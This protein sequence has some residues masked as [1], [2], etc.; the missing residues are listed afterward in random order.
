LAG[1]EYE[2]PETP[3]KEQWSTQSSTLGSIS[4]RWWSA[5]GDQYLNELIESAVAGSIDLQIAAGRIERAEALI[6][7]AGARRLPIIG[8]SGAAEYGIQS[9]SGG[10]TSSTESYGLGVGLNWEIDVWGK[11]KKGVAAAEAEYKAS[12]ADWRSAYL[13]LVSEAATEY[14]RLRQ[15][16]EQIHLYQRS[17]ENSE[18]TL[19][20]Y[21]IRAEED[22]VGR[23]VVLRQQAEVRR[24]QRELQDLERQRVI[25]ENGLA[26][27][28][29]KPAG[30]LSIPS[31]RMR[32]K[33]QAVEVPA[34][35]PADL[36]T[37]R[38]DILAAEYRV[39]A[40]YNLVGKARLDRLPS[41]ALTTSGG[42]A[43][44]SIGDLLTQWF[45]GAGPVISVPLFDPGRRAEVEVRQADLKIASDQ[46]RSVVIRAFQEVEDVLVN[47]SSRR[48]QQAIADQAVA[49]LQ[50][51]RDISIA[52]LDEG[53][54]SQLEVLE[55]ERSLLQSEQ[56]ALS[57]HFSLL[58][59]TVTLFKALG[60]GWDDTTVLGE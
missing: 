10:S 51:V 4:P 25:V 37:R 45:L 20:L 42:S 3:V 48:M 26:V 30:E 43:S 23:D 54:I 22:Y 57:L 32:D 41:I 16:D 38:P 50:N 56:A 28:T 33:L 11:L 9:S 35:L 60:G 46:Y 14:F 55:T 47:L 59:D 53:L 19:S 31:Q 8:G 21:S 49:D 34:G 12:G 58:N 7:T 40:A 44:A 39:L 36:L 18:R 15:M 6:G 1:P 17:L 24:L 5:F 29:G 13:V 52:K 27:L 2:P